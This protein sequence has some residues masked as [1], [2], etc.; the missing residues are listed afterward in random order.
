[1][2][3][4]PVFRCDTVPLSC[5]PIPISL[6]GGTVYLSLYATGIRAAE[7]VTVTIGGVQVQVLYAGPQQQYVGLDQVNVLVPE[8]LRGR[9]VLPITIQAGS[10]TSNSVV[11][12]IQ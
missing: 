5:I 2:T 7:T 4:V 3:P 6:Q 9:G 11:V 1:M 12:A 8:S 10:A